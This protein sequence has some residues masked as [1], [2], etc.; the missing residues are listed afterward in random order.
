MIGSARMDLGSD[1]EVRQR[2]AVRGGR[3]AMSPKTRSSS[4]S[5]RRRTRRRRPPSDEHATS[6]AERGFPR[7]AAPGVGLVGDEPT[8]GESRTMIVAVGDHQSAWLPTPSAVVHRMAP[9]VASSSVIGAAARRRTRRRSVPRAATSVGVPA[10]L[11]ASRSS[12]TGRSRGRSRGSRGPPTRRTRR[13]RRPTK[14]K[15]EP[16]NGP[17]EDRVAEPDVTPGAVRPSRCGPRAEAVGVRR[18]RRR[19][20][21]PATAGAEARELLA[22]WRRR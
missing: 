21:P 1:R 3:S 12:P 5:E 8:V 17:V 9:V 7:S 16:S 6:D 15:L 10:Q 13:G 18:S 14:A 11:G 4:A 19:G 20:A 22:G 2:G